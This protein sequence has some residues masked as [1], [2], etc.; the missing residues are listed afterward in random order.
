MKKA[1][2]CGH[3]Y[4]DEK[5][6]AK[7][8]G[9]DYKIAYKSEK[10]GHDTLR[11]YVFAHRMRTVIIYAKIA[12]CITRVTENF[13]KMLIICEHWSKPIEKK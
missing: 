9:R 3:E 2:P 11:E 7:Q 10:V 5:Q 12:N 13:L 4:S 8:Y 1:Q 6:N